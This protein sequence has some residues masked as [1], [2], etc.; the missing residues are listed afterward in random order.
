MGH[1]AGDKVTVAVETIQRSSG[2]A[3]RGDAGKVIG[4]TGDGYR[5]RFGDFI[6]E[7]V[8]PSEITEA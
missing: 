3:W 8:K 2:A 5:V 7:N 4:Q 6:A 1:K